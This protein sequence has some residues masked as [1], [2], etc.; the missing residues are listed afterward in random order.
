MPEKGVDV[1]RDA[2]AQAD[3][4]ATL[5]VV[6]GGPLAAALADAPSTRLL[7]PLPRAQ[8]P[9]AYAAAEFAIVPSVPTPRFLEPWG[10]VCNEAMHQAKPVIATTAVGAVAG[11]LVR[12]D[13][14]GLVIAPGD[15]Q[16]LARAIVLL[17]GDTPLRR[18]LGESARTA[19]GAYTY[20]AMAQAFDRAL[21]VALERPSK[22]PRHARLLTDREQ[23]LQIV[24]RVGLEGHHRVGP[25]D[26]FEAADLP[27]HDVR[28]LIRIAQ[29]QDR[30]EIPFARHRVRLGDALDPGELAAERGERDAI[31]VDQDDRVG[32][33]VWLWPG[34]S[35]TTRDAVADST[36]ALNACA[37]V[38]IGGNV[39]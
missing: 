6:G 37:S 32:H 2:W 5:V 18:R 30:D 19:V 4:D 39:L 12:D 13:E 31:G 33:G 22:G 29:P 27:R 34:S 15:A 23:R 7:G 38:S 10:L 25:R 14:T 11:G 3:A 35:T 21:A 36:S 24:T 16:M 9:A 26:S 8:M 17:L 28:Q 1:L 20:E